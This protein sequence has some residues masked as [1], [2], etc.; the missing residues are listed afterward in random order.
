[1]KKSLIA[2][3]VAG[4]LTVPM[5]AQADATLYGSL[6]IKLKDSDATD[7]DVQDNSSRI[8]I[9]GSSELFSGAKAIFRFEQSVSTETGGWAGSGRLAYL[10]ATGDFG[11]AL[12]GRIW[13]PHYNWTGAQTDILDNATSGFSSYVVGTHRVS[14]TM[15]YLTPEMGGFQAAAAVFANDTDGTAGSADNDDAD[16]VHVAATYGVNGFTVGASYLDIS[17]DTT[18]AA[19]GY[20]DVAAVSASYTTGGFYVAGR[21]EDRETAAGASQDAWELAASYTM[22]NTTFL[23]NYVEDESNVVGGKEEELYSLEVQ[24]KLGKQARVYFAL[25]EE[26]N[27]D[28][29]EAGYRVDF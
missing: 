29:F 8:G 26:G 7:M 11:T 9:R 4:A 24:Q 23:A 25:T 22:G 10:G 21:Y 19:M 5:V 27:N 13:S 28:G 3:A 12:F 20:E 1:M 14:N 6:R 17:G 18:E 2:L 15:A 16:I